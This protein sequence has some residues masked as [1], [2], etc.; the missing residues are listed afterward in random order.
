M[1]NHKQSIEHQ[2]KLNPPKQKVVKKEI[3]KW[4]D[5][6]VIYA[7]ANNSWVCNIQ[8][9]PKKGEM[10]VVSYDKYDLFPMRPVT[11]LR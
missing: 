11:R 2:R 7:I 9:V 6:G 4:L 3:I 5:F 10:N 1:P 8:C